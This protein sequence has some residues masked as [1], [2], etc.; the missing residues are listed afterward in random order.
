MLL[1]DENMPFMVGSQCIKILKNSM[2]DKW[3]SKFKI[4]SITGYVDSDNVN[5]IK[6]SGSDGFYSKPISA[7]MIND[8]LQQSEILKFNK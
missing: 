3:L 2:N 4:F 7:T 1:I 5:Y 6:H 8:L